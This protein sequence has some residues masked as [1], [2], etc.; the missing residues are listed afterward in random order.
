M[1][2]TDGCYKELLGIYDEVS[3]IGDI[4][5]VLNWDQYTYMPKMAAENRGSQFA[6]LSR[7]GH[8]KITDPR[9]GELVRCLKDRELQKEK[10]AVVREIGRV[11]ER[12]TAVPEELEAKS[13]EAADDSKEPQ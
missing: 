7:L 5:S 1:E 11:H 8:R 6:F 3:L 4:S 13:G 10:E 2:E 9:V 12:R